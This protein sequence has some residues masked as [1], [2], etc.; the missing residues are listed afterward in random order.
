MITVSTHLVVFSIGLYRVTE[1]KAPAGHRVTAQPFYVALPLTDP[2]KLNEWL[3]TVHVYPKNNKAADDGKK[4]VNDTKSLIDG[5]V[6]KYQINQP[7]E[8]RAEG[9]QPRSR[10]IIS[11]FYPNDRLTYQSLTVDGFEE[12]TDY[13]IDTNTEG[14][15]QVV[16][17]PAGLKKID[18]KSRQADQKIQVDL[19][20]KV[21]NAENKNDKVVNRFKV[22]EKFRQTP[23]DPDNPYAPE[24]PDSNDPDPT[25]PPAEPDPGSD[26]P[27]LKS[28]F[29]AVDIVKADSSQKRLEGAVFDLYTCDAQ[30]DLKGKALR[31]GI[32]SDNTA[33]PE[34]NQLRVNDWENNA[35]VL[36][37]QR[38]YYC[39][40]ENK[41]P[42]GYELSSQPIRFQVLR[43]QQTE[44][45]ALTSVNV[46]DVP[47]NAGFKLSLTG[48]TGIFVMLLAGGAIL[49]VGRGFALY[50]RR[51]A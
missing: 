12:N 18:D 47:S 2:T 5:K 45:I 7:L 39:L 14:V 44:T 51:K 34:I 26:N 28:Y 36:E 50:S 9:S 37:D 30:G 10:Y 21:V 4:T 27:W 24:D 25:D 38:S 33:K 8:Q 40:V 3:S 1:T 17:T 41:A 13:T 49:I 32:V 46:V 35:L 15:V 11:D 6:I 23:V 29:G 42:E 20:F 43:G 16:F 22:V 19:Q 31:T 48:G